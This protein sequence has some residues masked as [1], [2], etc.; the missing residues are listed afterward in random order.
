MAAFVS[1][2]GALA[3]YHTHR[4]YE[5]GQAVAAGYERRAASARLL[6][7]MRDAETGQRG[8]LLTGEDRYLEPARPGQ[9]LCR[10][11]AARADTGVS[12]AQSA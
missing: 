1:L 11:P 6:S 10:H 8:F 9:Q 5:N 2:S 3:Y 12:L 4:A 7:L